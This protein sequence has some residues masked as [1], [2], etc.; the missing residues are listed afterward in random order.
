M[1]YS[2]VVRIS[3]HILISN[4]V[5]SPLYPVPGRGTAAW[6][7]TIEGEEMPARA[8]MPDDESTKFGR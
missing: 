1:Q 4:S 7:G 2:V 8:R 6:M 3:S 5:G